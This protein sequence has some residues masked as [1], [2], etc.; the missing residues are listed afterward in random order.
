MGR[1][2][3]KTPSRMA[4]SENQTHKPL[5]EAAS[6]HC[7]ET[8]VDDLQTTKTKASQAPRGASTNQRPKKIWHQGNGSE[9]FEASQKYVPRGERRQRAETTPNHGRATGNE[10]NRESSQAA[11][12]WGKSGGRRGNGPR[13]DRE[14]PK[15]HKAQ[16]EAT[17]ASQEKAKPEFVLAPIPTEN[18]CFKTTAKSQQD[19]PSRQAT[20]VT[21]DSQNWW[22]PPPETQVYLQS[23]P[24]E[25]RLPRRLPRTA[26]DRNTPAKPGEVKPAPKPNKDGGCSSFTVETVETQ[27]CGRSSKQTLRLQALL[28]HQESHNTGPR[29]VQEEAQK[30]DPENTKQSDRFYG[31]IPDEPDEVITRPPGA[32]NK[33]R[34]KK[35]SSRAGFHFF[36]FGDEPEGG[37][38]YLN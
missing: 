20:E 17:Q 6:G 21:Y 8:M 2:N 5:A 25:Q 1:K 18:P 19:S 30:T 28:I 12:N 24:K 14:G 38:F 16:T 11:N 9:M 7:C 27:N 36:C 31:E 4:I 34:K 35:K 15:H 37:G 23:P 33:R 3:N 13:P 29:V 22:K 10:I 32:G 26:G